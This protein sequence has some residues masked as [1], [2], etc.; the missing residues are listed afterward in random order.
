M[1]NGKENHRSEEGSPEILEPDLE[2][3]Q[4]EY[5]LVQAWK[6]TSNYIRYHNWYADTL[7]LDWT[8]IN[9]PEFITGLAERLESPD[10]WQS[11]PLR[12][13][14]APKSQRWEDRN[15]NWK[16][17][18]GLNESRLRPLAH[19]SLRDQVA[20]TALMLCLADRVETIQGDP[21]LSYRNA[22]SRREVSSYG[23]RLF[24]DSVNGELRH[25]WGSSKLYRS[26]FQD[27]RAFIERPTAVAESIKQEDL[28]V[29]I[30]E[31]D[32][33][34]FYDRVRPQH[35]MRALKSFQ[36]S[37]EEQSFFDLAG[38]IL[39]WNWHGR[40]DD[41]AHTYAEAAG[42]G[43]FTQVA[44]PQGLVSAG[45]FAN[46]VLIPFD[47]ALRNKIGLEI[48]EDIYL[49]D[50]CRYV[51][52]LRIVVATNQSQGE[53]REAACDWL[54]NM[55][56]SEAPGLLLSIDKTKAVE[57]GGSQRPLV[58]QSRRMERIQSAVSGGFDAITGAEVL[59][60]IKGLMRSQESLSQEV[61]NSGWQFSPL[62]DVRD[63]TV[64]RFSAGRFRTTYRSI[65]P[66]LEEDRVAEDV[67]VKDT[68]IVNANVGEITLRQ[69]TKQ[70]LDDDAQAF[71]LELIGRWI[72]D[73]SNVRLLRI[74][75]DIWPDAE[76]L[77]DVLGRLRPFTKP[78][79]PRKM[80]RRVAW[81]CLGEILRAGATET[82]LTEDDECLPERVDLD[83][84]REVLRD[85]AMRLTMLPTSTIPWYLR[86]QAMLFLAAFD[87]DGAP[88]VRVSRRAEI[89]RYHKLILFLRGQKTR[90][91]NAEFST[92][93][94][95]SR[96]AFSQTL[97]ALKP[98]TLTIAQRRGIASRDPSFVLELSANN[99]HFFDGLP[100]GIRDDLCVDVQSKTRDRRS[101]VDVVLDGGPTNPLRNELSLLRFSAELLN[102]IQMPGA[103]NYECI[104]PGQ[105]QLNLECKAGVAERIKLEVLANRAEGVGSLYEVPHWCKST[106]R[107]RFQ[108][109]FL[110]RFILSGQPDF[111]AVVH[112]I[113][114]RA[115]S[116][117]YQ[118]VRNHWY[119]RLYGLSTKQQ[120]FGDDW[121]P[122]TEW[123]EQFLLALLRWPGCRMP[124]GFSW[125][126]C[127]IEKARAKTKDRIQFLEEQR[128][129]ATEVLLLPMMAGRR[130]ISPSS[131]QLR[132]C[133]VQ[134]VVP[135]DIDPMDLTY[136]AS[137]N[138][139]RHRN[140][141]SA[142]LQA[143][144]R[145]LDLRYTH[146]EGPRRLDWLI[147]PEL[148]VHPDDVQTH[149]VPF[150][151][152]H[153][154][155]IL[156]GL[157]YVELFPGQPLVN[158]ALWILPEQTTNY[159]LQIRIRRQGKGYLA[160]EERN[161]NVQGF[162]PCQWLIG[163]P[164]SE[165][166][167]PLWLTGSICYDATDLRLASDLR[168]KSDVFAIPALNKDV[169]TFD[170]MAVALHYHMYQLV[171]VA[172]NGKFGGSN[173]YW[174]ST[175]PNKR[176]VFHSHGQ[177]QASI[178]FL[179]INIG[180]FLKR[181]EQASQSV[182]HG[183]NGW[184]HP[185]VG[186]NGF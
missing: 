33:S 18:P 41:Y 148:A 150:A 32:L 3:L 119:Q 99:P 163:Y 129:P 7:E 45:F 154:T 84:Y 125:V 78:G 31:S 68:E 131:D 132:A 124:S 19:V 80:A 79:G 62:P 173:A 178:A 101:L 91:T 164:W 121:V 27:Y 1:A 55:L 59:D 60:A 159:G 50:T 28:R 40:D 17:T 183:A 95:L 24:S 176:Q 56:N 70:D 151:R 12:L 137:N 75:F 77:R 114:W 83:D 82:G 175:D 39:N 35:L 20:A 180:E 116:G 98:E 166:H 67:V 177:P 6:K 182:A 30:I 57:F 143:V 170:Q 15:G 117:A 97:T 47:H 120:A 172:N 160:H 126:E 149:L 179:D 112:P 105:V 61:T 72:A 102:R 51:D 11:E 9:L 21:R 144:R 43:D 171:V 48:A 104:T 138:R 42:L 36:R 181:G 22:K 8:T 135:D 44:L 113:N 162:R 64:A 94:V 186:L 128:G 92:L 161:Y 85:E 10:L 142:A 156:T 115:H 4:Q 65:R 66:L 2:L 63:D 140:H 96:R 118:P 29:F 73:P 165:D 87:P 34:Q 184:K 13:V 174:P 158:S 74:G 89:V 136:S 88:I 167:R 90:F 169:K 152:Q 38:R 108:L 103:P 58:R 37:V 76:V 26:Y 141:L 23:N 69:R 146:Q 71:A 54:Q 86:Q 25:R 46:V 139:R 14:P 122:L 49:A 153:K 130:P 93:A 16:P 107:W 52:D 111:T 157:T 127:G 145:M 110:L 100:A 155:L 81:Y 185:P 5:V 147:L 123:M 109:G 133:V 134:T 53:V 106:D 168:D